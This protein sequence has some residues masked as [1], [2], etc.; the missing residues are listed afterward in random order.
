MP[1]PH[2]VRPLA[3][4]LPFLT[5]CL[6]L[7]CGGPRAEPAPAPQGP[8]RLLVLSSMIGYIEPCGCTVDLLLGGVDR[9]VARVAAERAEGPTA[10]L[11]VGPTFF[12]GAVKAHQVGQE[13]SK[14]RLLGDAL[15]RIGVDAFVPGASDLGQGAAFYDQAAAGL[16]DVTVNVPGGVGRILPLGALKVGLLGVAPAGVP[17]KGGTSTDPLPAAQAAAQALRAQGAQVIV[18]LAA[19]TRAD[20]RPVS[21]GVEGVDLW[22]LGDHPDEL[23]AATAVG[24]TYVIEAGDR[25]RNLGRVLLLDAAGPG[26]LTDPV[27]DH[28]RQVQR[29]KLQ[30]QMRKDMAARMPSPQLKAAIAGL[31]A[32][33]AALPP[34]QAT[35]K[36]FEYSLIPLP[37]DAP[38]DPEVTGWMTR[39]NEALKAMN[40]AAAGDIPPV[41]AGGQAFVGDAQCVD[42]HDE[43]MQVWKQT[44]HARAWQTLVDAGKTFD[45]EC[46]SC[47]VVGFQQPGGTVMGKTA[48]K[49]AVQCEACH[50]PGEKHVEMGGGEAY[51]RLRVPEEVCTQCHNRKHSPKF[52]YA[53]YLPKIL[54]PGHQKRD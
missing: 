13:E 5:A 18:G 14:A 46:V 15:R 34:P 2:R 54:G 51:T 30:I 21:R 8:P 6:L 20:L 45:A 19:L 22:I 24:D 40:L 26:R 39:W 12:D 28:A 43:P 42:C 52:D 50:G 31:E 10:V 11:V 16:P 4:T 23:E 53:T 9:A 3:P 44:P 37:K 27:G 49:E 38:A 25:G 41:P 36:R 17:L 7:A 29:L 35:G 33:L 48:G 47:H 1:R 32:E